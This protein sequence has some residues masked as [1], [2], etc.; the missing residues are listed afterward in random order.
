M[1]HA[2][3]A[4]HRI[5]PAIIRRRA[6]PSLHAFAQPDV[7]LL[8][9]AAELPIRYSRRSYTDP[10]IRRV[11]GIFSERLGWPPYLTFLEFSRLLTR[12][13]LDHHFRFRV[14]LDSVSPLS[15]QNS[16][17]AFFPSAEREVRHR[18]RHAT[19]DSDIPRRR[20][21]AK[22]PRRRA[23]RGEERRL[24]PVRASRQ[25]L[26]RFIHR[27]RMHQ[28]QYRPKNFRVRQLARRRQAI[29]N[30]GL[31]EIAVLMTRNF[32]VAPV[33]H[34]LGAFT[35][36]FINQRFDALLAFARDH[37]PHRSE[38][39][40]SELQSQFHLVCRLLLEKKN[41]SLTY[42]AS[43]SGPRHCRTPPFPRP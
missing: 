23:A 42:R 25:K 5:P 19:I 31:H 13:P 22:S 26:H 24:V 6:Q 43:T 20:F 35:N 33:H 18:R 28:A 17:E 39:H 41:R 15:V 16:E 7:F 36:A 34:R 12:P 14:E 30:R 40:T 8:Y 4:P 2:V 1:V 38:E 9:L 10:S 32:R 21:I 27:T 11:A 37:G 3:F 29:Q